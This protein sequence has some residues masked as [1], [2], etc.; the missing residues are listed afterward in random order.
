MVNRAL[1]STRKITGRRGQSPAC[2]L[3]RTSE[4]FELTHAA[5]SSL[6]RQT[7][8]FGIQFLAE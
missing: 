5:M 6:V 1:S 3:A 7:T 8:F 2:C 4:I